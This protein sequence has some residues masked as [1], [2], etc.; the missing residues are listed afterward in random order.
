ML[1]DHPTLL[2]ET[3][4]FILNESKKEEEE[5]KGGGKLTLDNS[6]L[7]EIAVVLSNITMYRKKL[8]E[9]KEQILKLKK[10]SGENN[11]KSKNNDELDPLDDDEHVVK[12]KYW[13]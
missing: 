4:D 1:I 3:F 11:N 5:E 2:K 7:Y 10:L 12:R 6:I 8:N 13:S 9:T